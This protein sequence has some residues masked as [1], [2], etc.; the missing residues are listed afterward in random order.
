[1]STKTV[2]ICDY[3]KK[4]LSGVRINFR[5][6]ITSTVSSAVTNNIANSPEIVRD[7]YPSDG[8]EMCSV[9]CLNAYV[10]NTVTPYFFKASV[11]RVSA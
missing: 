10:H 8:T 3:C 11:E 7:S 6:V 1:M 2:S 5:I 9:E 4:E